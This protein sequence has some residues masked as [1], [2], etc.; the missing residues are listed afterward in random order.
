VRVLA[1]SGLQHL[2]LNS[3]IISKVIQ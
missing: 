1:N 2:A 3:H